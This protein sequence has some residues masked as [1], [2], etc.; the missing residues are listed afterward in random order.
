[1]RWLSLPDTAVLQ[2][3]L[4]GDEHGNSSISLADDQYEQLKEGRPMQ[5]EREGRGLSVNKGCHTVSVLLDLS[6][7]LPFISV[8]AN[9]C[10]TQDLSGSCPE[11]TRQGEDFEESALQESANDKGRGEMTG[12]REAVGG[13]HTARRDRAKDGHVRQDSVTR[14]QPQAAW[15]RR[16][17]EDEHERARRHGHAGTTRADDALTALP[18]PDKARG[19]ARASMAPGNADESGALRISMPLAGAN[20]CEG[21]LFVQ[22]LGLGR[23][24]PLLD[25]EMDGDGDEAGGQRKAEER[26]ERGRAEREVKVTLRLD[27][28]YLVSKDVGDLERSKDF[29]DLLYAG[30]LLDLPRQ[31]PHTFPPPSTQTGASLSLSLSVSL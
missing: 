27:G 5:W 18:A 29:S 11:S 15:A 2:I 14:S 28:V 25:L 7:K 21:H 20:V 22:V 19:S 6:T 12:T 16:D 30:D 9:F 10:V 24:G 17:P 4:N 23:V 26:R 1:M 3:V 13:L 31:Y 8:S